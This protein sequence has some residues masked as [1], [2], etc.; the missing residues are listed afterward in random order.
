MTVL[1]T[2]STALGQTGDLTPALPG[3]VAPDVSSER[4]RMVIDADR[5]LVTEHAR[6]HSGWTART[7]LEWAHRPLSWVSSDDLVV[8]I[9]DHAVAAN[10]GAA[11][12]VGPVRV[13]VSA[14][15]WLLTTG[16][17]HEGPAMVIGDPTLDLKVAAV[18]HPEAP[19]GAALVGRLGIGLGASA[20]QLGQAGPFYEVGVAVDG[21][22]GPL[23][24]ALN[25]GLRGVPDTAFGEVEVGDVAWYRGAVSVDVNDAS[26]VFV[27]G[28]GEAP[29][30]SAVGN[31]VPLEL[32]AGARFRDDGGFG[33]HG[34]VGRGI[35][36]GIG[37]PVLRLVVGVSWR[38]TVASE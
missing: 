19:F 33:V 4:Y 29:V 18:P 5:S 38:G 35:T 12:S 23:G 9:V 34:G 2:L 20:R 30:A 15:A 25:G 21:R 36:A 22:G 27:E 11:G 31:T 6:I 37:S 1:L 3:Y 24:G 8:H 14:P 28:F 7:E 10:L 32:L 26:A 16:A 17:V 13:G